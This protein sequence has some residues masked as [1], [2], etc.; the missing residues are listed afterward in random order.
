MLLRYVRR[1]AVARAERVADLVAVEVEHGSRALLYR[2]LVRADQEVDVKPAEN[3]YSAALTAVGFLDRYDLVLV[4]VPTVELHVLDHVLH[5][6]AHV[7][8]GGDR[9]NDCRSSG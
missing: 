3:G 7:A 6:V 5:N 9:F 4:G 2:L 8:A 1:N